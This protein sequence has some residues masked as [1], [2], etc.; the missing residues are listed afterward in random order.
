[1]IIYQ[2]S[3]SFNLVDFGIEVPLLDQRADLTYQQLCQSH[4][5]KSWETKFDIQNLQKSDLLRVHDNKFIEE[6]YQDPKKCIENC[7][8]LKDREGNYNRYTP[9]NQIKDF[10]ELVQT[11]LALSWC[12]YKAMDLALQ[13]KFQYF[14]SG[15]MHHAMSFGPRGFC[16]VNDIV[17]G[18]KKL[19]SENKIKTAWIID[20]DAHKGD[21]TAELTKDDSHIVTLSIH[22]KNSWPLENRDQIDIDDPC[23]ISSDVEIELDKNQEDKYIESLNKGLYKLSSIIKKPDLVIIVNGA[24]PYIEDSLPSTLDLQLSLGQ[25]LERDLLVYNFLK[26]RDIPQCYLMAGGYGENVHKVYY[27]FLNQIISESDQE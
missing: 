26:Q 6:I 20:V 9:E 24:D 14:L 5:N 4:P 27:Q 13:S 23:L 8:E 16:L 19:I 17:I 21:G 3:I 18:V 25:M 1:M 15:G 12:S 10:S 7:Y 11:H 22:M 2:P